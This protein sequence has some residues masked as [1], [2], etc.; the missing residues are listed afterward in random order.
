MTEEKSGAWLRSEHKINAQLMES[1][2]RHVCAV[3]EYARE[4][5]LSRLQHTVAR[6][7]VHMKGHMTAEEDSGGF[8]SPVL[9]RR[10]TLSKEVEGLRQE[11][12][13]LAVWLD[14]IY[15]QVAELGPND[16]LLINDACQ[17]I[18]HL[19]S[20]IKHHEEHEHLLVTFVFSQDIGTT[21]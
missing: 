6:F 2:A 14:R 21:D 8:M 5:W 4:E 7:R 20:T 9:E 3:P 12:A 16:T 10:P 15:E 19:V 1:L 13:Q 18:Q 11:H 17:R